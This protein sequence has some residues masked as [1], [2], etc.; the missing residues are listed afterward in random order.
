MKCQQECS[1]TPE[2]RDLQHEEIENEYLTYFAEIEDYEFLMRFTDNQLPSMYSH[3]CIVLKECLNGPELHAHIETLFAEA[4]KSGAKHLYIVLHPNHEFA[5]RA[6]EADTFEQSSLLYMTVPFDE[7]RGTKAHSDC[8]V[9]EVTSPELYQDAVLFDIA[10]SVAEEEKHANYRFSYK[11]AYRKLPVFKQHAP[12]L[13]QYVAYLDDIPVGKC[14]ISRHQEVLRLESFSVIV[15][16]QRK[17]I[18][19]AILNKIAEDG[20]VRRAKEF[21]LVADAADTAKEMYRKLGFRTVGV[22]HQLLWLKNE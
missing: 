3:N 1:I 21:F 8:K 19:T 15:E 22:E 4:Q 13:S 7:Y 9:Y 10:A 2:R 18:G 17:G 16:C 12:A 6:W 14:E 11:R 20:K 5:I